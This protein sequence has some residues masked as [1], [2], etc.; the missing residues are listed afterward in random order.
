M[1]KLLINEQKLKE[2]LKNRKKPIERTSIDIEDIKKNKRMYV[3]SNKAGS[4]LKAGIVDTLITNSNIFGKLKKNRANIAIFEVDERVS[5]YIYNDIKPKY[6][7]ITNILRDSV[8]RNANTDYIV[9]ILR[10]KYTRRNKNN[11]ESEMIL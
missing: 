4:N 2:E 11:S 1:I 9:D 8:K 6:T 5:P 10:R 3:I 7:I